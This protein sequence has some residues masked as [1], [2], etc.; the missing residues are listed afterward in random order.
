MRC[1][2]SWKHT[3]WFVPSAASSCGMVTWFP[4]SYCLPKSLRPVDRATIWLSSYF[5]SNNNDIYETTWLRKSP[6]Y[7]WHEMH[8][9][10][11]YC[12]SLL[13]SMH[14]PWF[15]LGSSQWSPVRVLSQVRGRE[16]A[17]AWER[18]GERGRLGF[19]SWTRKGWVCD[20]S[21]AGICP[22]TLM[23]QLPEA[24]KECYSIFY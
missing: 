4:G 21:L 2:H 23:K 11:C 18:E 14:A 8:W 6:W 12:L 17:R 22:K 20:W 9:P 16:R 5:T 24:Q 19:S 15:S 1:V 7:P 13:S 10:P 3:D